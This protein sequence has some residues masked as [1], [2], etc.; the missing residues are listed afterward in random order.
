MFS[1][2]PDKG[3]TADTTPVACTLTTTGLLTQSYRWE[4]LLAGSARER[5]ETSDGLRVR[6]RGDAATVEELHDLVS[7]ESECCAW[8]SWAVI[9]GDG[10][11][12]TS[13]VVRSTG[14]GIAMLHRMLTLPD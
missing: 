11:G 14:D 10:D 3:S 1:Q 8:A 5:V 2:D 12:I 7:V 6:F 4:R 13:L 9:D